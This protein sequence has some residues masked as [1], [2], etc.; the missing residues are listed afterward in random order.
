MKHVTKRDNRYKLSP[1]GAVRELKLNKRKRGL[2]G[3]HNGINN[4]LMLEK[5]T[6]W[7]RKIFEH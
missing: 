2:R 4:P 1:F 5:P 6:G 7:Y 3:G